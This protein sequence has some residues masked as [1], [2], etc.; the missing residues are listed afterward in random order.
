MKFCRRKTA[1]VMSYDGD[2]GGITRSR[3]RDDFMAEVVKIRSLGVV[4]ADRTC[5]I[6]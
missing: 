1:F 4:L 5:G 2:S 3:N 6:I